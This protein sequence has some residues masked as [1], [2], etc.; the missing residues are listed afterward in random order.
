MELIAS[1]F[2]KALKLDSPWHQGRLFPKRG[3]RVG[4]ERS[5]KKKR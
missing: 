4:T 1:L 2:E 5:G 3:E